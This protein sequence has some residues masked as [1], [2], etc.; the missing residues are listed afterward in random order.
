MTE[1][2]RIPV[3][4][5]HMGLRLAV[6]AAFFGV[7]IGVSMLLI[8]LLPRDL[9][10]AYVVVGLAA[11]Y[12]SAQLIEH[13]LKGRWHSGRSV[14]LDPAG[15]RLLSKGAVERS[16]AVG[17]ETDVLFWRF[18]IRNRRG[19]IPK[20]WYLLACALRQQDKT[21][22]VYTFMSPQAVEALPAH[23]RFKLLQ[24][25]ER[26]RNSADDMRLAGEQRR[27]YEAESQRWREGAEMPADQF[28]AYTDRIATMFGK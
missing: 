17:L 26:G 23:D 27:L 7:T 5:E 3:D 9:C 12:G 6:T 24:A 10:A 8:A 28:I 22:A 14:E 19:M 25:R 1:T 15:V 2:L 21:I 11:G 18:E 16:A 4:P 20:G 13:Q